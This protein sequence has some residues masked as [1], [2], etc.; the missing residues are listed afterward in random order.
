MSLRRIKAM[1]K[2]EIIQIRRDIR[3]LIAAIFIPTLLILLFGYALSLDVDNIPTLVL[4]LDR[5]PASRDLIQRLDDSRYFTIVRYIQRQNEI[6][7]ALAR[8]EA[9]MAL[10]IPSDF[11][12]PR[13]ILWGSLT[14]SILTASWPGCVK[15]AF[16]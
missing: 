14:V 8:R 16:T 1:A 7:P 10:V 13:A 11:S 12:S 15:R 6:E 4:D 2:K 3:V 5:T 9:F